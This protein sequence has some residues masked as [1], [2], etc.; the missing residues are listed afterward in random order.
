M[1]FMAKWP[2][3]WRCWVR[4]TGSAF[5]MPT[6]T[7][8]ATVTPADRPRAA[9]VMPLVTEAFHPAVL[10]AASAS[11]HSGLEFRFDSWPSTKSADVSFMSSRVLAQ[12]S[13]FV[14]SIV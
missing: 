11:S 10:A 1:C 4:T 6:L 12:P 7:L 13:G 14:V 8:A 5:D 9:V 3:S 2:V